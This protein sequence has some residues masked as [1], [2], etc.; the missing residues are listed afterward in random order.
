MAYYIIRKCDQHD[1][2]A[3]DDEGADG[4]VRD[5]GGLETVQDLAAIEYA[6]EEADVDGVEEG[7]V[8][9]MLTCMESIQMPG[10]E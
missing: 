7:D 9:N 1:V 5:D 10:K 2:K 8:Q 3:D 6:E 4:D